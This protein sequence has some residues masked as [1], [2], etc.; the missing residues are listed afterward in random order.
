MV[1]L[2][3]LV[4]ELRGRLEQ[5]AD[6][7]RAP[8]MAAYMQGRFPFL[9]VGAADVRRAAKV[10]I[11]DGRGRP[12]TELVDAADALWSEPEREFQYVGTDLLR[13]W[14]GVLTAADL[15]RVERLVR[16]KSWWDTVDALAAHVVG[17]LV[18]RCPELGATMD[19]WIDDDDIWVA[20]TAILHQLA[21]KD[22]TDADRLFRY[23][24]TRSGDTEF[25]IRKACGWALRQYAY[26]EPDAVR[27]YVATRGERLSGL[28]RREAT[29]HL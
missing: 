27:R 13:R 8:K 11:A 25:F 20:R 5:F 22:R 3:A 4:P 1:P 18:A 15:P 23:V 28:T 14:S 7:V 10:F 26:V 19:R 12:A 24:D 2:A 17:E 16:A 21:W 9:G 6:P 29:K